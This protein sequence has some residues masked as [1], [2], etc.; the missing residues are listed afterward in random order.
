MEMV[1]ITETE[2]FIVKIDSRVISENHAHIIESC[3]ISKLMP[4]L[5]VILVLFA[6][7]HLY[8]SQFILSFVAG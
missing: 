7:L 2:K 3:K 4:G 5:T 1:F 6:S 8:T